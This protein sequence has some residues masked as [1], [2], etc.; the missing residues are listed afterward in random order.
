MHGVIERVGGKFGGTEK[1]VGSNCEVFIHGVIDR[2]GGNFI[3]GVENT[4]GLLNFK[5]SWTLSFSTSA[6][7]K[8]SS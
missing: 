6:L 3:D 7:S 5:V 8:S 2:V 1:L 4:D